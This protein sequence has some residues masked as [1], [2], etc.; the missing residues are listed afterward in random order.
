M[1]PEPAAWPRGGSLPDPSEFL[2]LVT[3]RRQSRTKSLKL[4]LW[5]IRV[6]LTSHPH[7]SG[8]TAAAF[9]IQSISLQWVLLPVPHLTAADLGWLWPPLWCKYNGFMSQHTHAT[10]H[11]REILAWDR[12]RHMLANRAGWVWIIHCSPPYGPRTTP[13][14]RSSFLQVAVHPPKF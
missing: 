10:E 14:I 7:S 9:W 4:H 12:V 5:G 1:K 8:C 11:W 3:G 2:P 6:L 13:F